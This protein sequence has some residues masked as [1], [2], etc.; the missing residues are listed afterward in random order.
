MRGMASAPTVLVVV[1]VLLVVHYAPTRLRSQIAP[2]T[3]PSSD[4]SKCVNEGFGTIKSPAPRVY[5][6]LIWGSTPVFQWWVAPD[7]GLSECQRI[8]KEDLADWGCKFVSYDQRG[9]ANPRCW[10]HQVGG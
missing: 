5:G 3:C 4:L 7:V 2:P 6:Q 9:Y 10:V 1:L 8:C